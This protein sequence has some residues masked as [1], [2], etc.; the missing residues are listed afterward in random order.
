MSGGSTELESANS[1]FYDCFEAGD[2]DAMAGLW[3]H[4]DEVFCV[5][6]G[7]EIIVGWGPVRRSWA[8]IFAAAEHL[9]FIVTDVRAWRHGDTGTVTCT[10]NILS[11]A[12]A[13]GD[14]GAG[15]A[16]A[17]NLFARRGGRWLLVAHHASPVLRRL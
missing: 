17:T 2:L 10:E 16:V 5:H 7:S 3:H 14:L 13:G 1:D 8:V 4:G 9:Q 15:K 12:S 6:P 11:A